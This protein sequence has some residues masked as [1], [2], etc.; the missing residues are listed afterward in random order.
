[1]DREAAVIRSEMSQTRADLDRKLSQ[2]QSR[3]RDMTPRRYVER[4]MPEYAWERAIGSALLVV[5]GW[6]AWKRYRAA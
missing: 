5:G 2:L 6:M 4:H 3:A 1:M